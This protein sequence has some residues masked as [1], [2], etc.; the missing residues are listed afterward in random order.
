MTIFY[1]FPHL[2]L[3]LLAVLHTT[4]RYAPHGPWL[5][6]AAITAENTGART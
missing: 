5:A 6:H 2:L 4:M 3:L 1:S